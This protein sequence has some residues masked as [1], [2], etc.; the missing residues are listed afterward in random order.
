LSIAAQLAWTGTTGIPVS[1]AGSGVIYF[2]SGT[3]TFRVS[4]NGGAFVDL[5][6][7]GDV[8]G[9]ASSTA[10]AIPLYNGTTGKLIKNS[11]LVVDG[12][13][14]ITGAGNYN[15]VTVTAHAARH[16]PGGADAL[17]TAAPPQGIG[18]A[19]TEGTASTFARSDHNHTLRSGSVDLTLG[20]I[21]DGQYLKRVG[22]VVQ[23]AAAAGAAKTLT[24]NFVGTLD[25]PIVATARWYPPSSSTVMRAWASLGE[26][27]SGTT[28]FDVLKNGVSILP[29]PI[30]IATGDYR[31]LDVIVPSVVVGI[32]DYLTMSLT[33]A[34]GGSNAVVFIEYE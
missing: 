24:G 1:A 2:D 29:V 25:A 21:A 11:T 26:N 10:N 31:S 28:E 17:G 33:T 4:Q 22:T 13:S 19:N 15:G 16:A 8:Q 32:N 30:S 14:N 20:A 34:N 27:A 12:S 18:A 7:S 3:N 23:G 6:I 5:S 9:P